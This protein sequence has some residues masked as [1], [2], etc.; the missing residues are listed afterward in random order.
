MGQNGRKDDVDISRKQTS[1]VQRSAEKQKAGGK[2]S[3]HYCA[4]QD[5][6]T[7]IFAQLLL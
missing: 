5:T 7:T 6:I 1:I 2:L 3:I 4:N